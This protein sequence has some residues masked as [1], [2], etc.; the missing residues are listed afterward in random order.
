[1]K[2]ERV[3]NVGTFAELATEFSTFFPNNPYAEGTIRIYL[4]ESLTF[5][6]LGSCTLISAGLGHLGPI[7][8]DMTVET[9]AHSPWHVP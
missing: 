8:H 4:P 6:S 3:R 2:D 1:M 9:E 5:F 7:F